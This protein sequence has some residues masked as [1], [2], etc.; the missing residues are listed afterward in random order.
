MW[1]LLK[2]VTKSLVLPEILD[3]PVCL[4]LSLPLQRTKHHRVLASFRIWTLLLH[5]PT[6]RLH[7]WR[8]PLEEKLSLINHHRSDNCLS[9][10]SKDLDLKLNKSGS[11]YFRANYTII[12]TVF[13]S[14][15]TRS[16][17][18]F[19]HSRPTCVTLAAHSCLPCSTYMFMLHLM[20]VYRTAV[21]LHANTASTVGAPAGRRH[22]QAFQHKCLHAYKT[23]AWRFWR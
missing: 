22:L 10:R 15:P 11:H 5:F 8:A 21:M 7:P 18:L 3:L 23:L 20:L 19:P 17:R 13:C 1:I 14:H 6:V 16:T 2:L 12:G 4:P 9:R